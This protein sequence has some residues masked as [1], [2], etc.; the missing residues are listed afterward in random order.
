MDWSRFRRG[1]G[2]QGA[3]E[4]CNYWECRLPATRAGLEDGVRK[5]ILTSSPCSTTHALRIRAEHNVVNEANSLRP[6]AMYLWT[7]PRR[8]LEYWSGYIVALW[9]IVYVHCQDKSHHFKLWKREVKLFAIN[10]HGA[11]QLS[12][13]RHPFSRRRCATV[14]PGHRD[15]L[16]EWH[17]ESVPVP[18]PRVKTRHP[19]LSQPELRV[20]FWLPHITTR[21]HGGGI[22]VQGC[23]WVAVALW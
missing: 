22:L 17:T 3:E 9:H 11:R 12:D 14:R 2:R 6:A 18:R 13:T 4:G 8:R 16:L 20:D 23:D 15:S 19:K 5:A 1:P 7:S 10:G 21:F